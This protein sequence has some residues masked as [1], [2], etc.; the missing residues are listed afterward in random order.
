MLAAQLNELGVPQGPEAP[1][2]PNRQHKGA[3]PPASTSASNSAPANDQ[4]SKQMQQ[5]S[6]ILDQVNQSA[7]TGFGNIVFTSLIVFKYI[8]ITFMTPLLR[9]FISH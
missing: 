4:N 8:F 6:S 5:S 3:A 9:S 1:P 7:I 2:R